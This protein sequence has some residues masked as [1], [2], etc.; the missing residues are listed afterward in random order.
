[1][2]GLQRRSVERENLFQLADAQIGK[3]PAIH[4]IKVRNLSSRGLMGE[5][6]MAVS[7]G[8]RLVVSLA[9]V[10][11]VSGT[12]VWVQDPRFGMAFDDELPKLGNS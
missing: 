9:D 2:A 4:R 11:E 5:A 10:G 12:I 7:S 1:M 3:D 6:P 8:T